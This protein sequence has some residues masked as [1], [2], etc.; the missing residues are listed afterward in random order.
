MAAAMLFAGCGSQSKNM[1]SLETNS[2]ANNGTLT[3]SVTAARA[4]TP[5]IDGTFVTGL[6]DPKVTSV[7]HLIDG[8]TLKIDADWIKWDSNITSA[9]WRDMDHNILSETKLLERPLY[10]D[11]SYDP[12]EKGVTKYIKTVT[13]T[14]AAGEEASKSYIVYVHKNRDGSAQAL[15]GPL[16]NAYWRVDSRS[17]E[18]MIAEGVTTPGD[19]AHVANAGRIFLDDASKAKVGD[20]YYV[21]TTAWGEDVDAD[22]NGEWDSTPTPNQGKLHVVVDGKRLKSGDYH[23]TALSEFFYYYL[24][25][26]GN[27]H[28]MDDAALTADLNEHAALVF[29]SDVD[30]DGKIDYGDVLHWNPATDRD[31]LTDEFKKAVGTMTENIL[32]G[33]D[34]LDGIDTSGES[35]ATPSPVQSCDMTA[36]PEGAWTDTDGS[37]SN[38]FDDNCRLIEQNRIT[39]EDASQIFVYDDAGNLVYR[40]IDYGN[41]GKGVGDSEYFYQNGKLVKTIFYA[42]DHSDITDYFYDDE[43]YLV[44]TR[45]DEFGNGRAIYE[46]YYDRD[47]NVI[48][49][50]YVPN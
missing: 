1:R 14:D 19:G 44:K 3:L 31:K 43:G 38:I 2:V 36:L 23:V 16:A 32:A 18:A 8:Q 9:V 50:G 21:T 15:L 41:D 4:E 35:G 22:D 17:G 47:G 49:E 34:L 37:V 33:R 11:P 25:V 10:Y 7:L 30:G 20:G 29:K 39:G 26:T 13:V 45:E 42:D 27:L 48:R 5:G 6:T 24:R 28:T 12:Q 46:T 40:T